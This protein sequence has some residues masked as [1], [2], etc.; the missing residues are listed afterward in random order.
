VKRKDKNMPDCS[1]AADEA[2]SAGCSYALDVKKREI[3]KA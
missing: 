1:P 2:V 3:H